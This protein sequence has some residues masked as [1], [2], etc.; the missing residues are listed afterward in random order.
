[1]KLSKLCEESLP[2]YVYQSSKCSYNYLVDDCDQMMNLALVDV[3]CMSIFTDFDETVTY[4]RDR[5]HN[6]IIDDF[7]MLTIDS[8]Q[9]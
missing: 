2:E 8:T 7:S 3:S 1:M 6:R 9:S 4:D 5:S